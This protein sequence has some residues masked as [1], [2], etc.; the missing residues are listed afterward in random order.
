M[1]SICYWYNQIDHTT[2]MQIC[3]TQ[4]DLWILEGILRIIAATN[5]GAIA[6]FQAAVKEI[7]FIRFGSSAMKPSGS[8]MMTGGSPMGGMGGES[9]SGMGMDGRLQQRWFRR[10]PNGRKQR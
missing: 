6:N 5:D 1:D 2:T 3:Y 8:V 10:I 4:E 7:E 9:S